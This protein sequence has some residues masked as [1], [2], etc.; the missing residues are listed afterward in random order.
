MTRNDATRYK[1][2]VL[3]YQPNSFKDKVELSFVRA[4][5]TEGAVIES[6]AHRSIMAIKSQEQEVNR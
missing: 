6:M 5:Y 4:A 3:S 1:N 2:Y